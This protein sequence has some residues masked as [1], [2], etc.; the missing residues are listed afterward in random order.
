MT[1]VWTCMNFV[2]NDLVLCVS[3]SMDMYEPSISFL[4]VS[5]SMDMYEPSIGFL[6]VSVS[7]D[8]YEP[9]GL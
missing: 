7:M 4:C 8:M 6:C 9:S 5:V 2:W 1:F 3:V